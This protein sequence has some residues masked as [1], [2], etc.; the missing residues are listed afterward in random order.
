MHKENKMPFQNA[1]GHCEG[2]ALQLFPKSQG[3]SLNSDF[4]LVPLKRVISHGN[5]SVS[6]NPK[7]LSASAV[8]GRSPGHQ[9]KT[10][11]F[12]FFSKSK[13][14]PGTVNSNAGR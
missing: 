3:E 5:D 11:F 10:I 1:S 8:T 9:N 7:S 4:L 13:F 12:F 6:K 14:H 2:P